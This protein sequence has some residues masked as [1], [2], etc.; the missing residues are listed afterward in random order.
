[1][2]KELSQMTLEELWQLFPIFLTEHKPFWRSWFEEEYNQLLTILPMADVVRISHIGSTAIHNIW[3]K[4][5]IDI[6]VEIRCD[7]E[8]NKM[9]HIIQNSGYILM[10][11]DKMQASFNKGYTPYG[12]AEKVF[13][14][15]LRYSNDNDELYFRDYLNDNPDIAKEYEQ[16]KLAL[17]A[18]HEHNRDAYTE[19]KTDFIKM[20]TEAA[21]AVYG[22]RYYRD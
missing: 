14:L 21:K 17:W 15:H 3:A 16:M 19:S 10:Y 11:S 9:S 13:H 2:K 1:M 22:K 20:H 18:Q 6:L 5:I 4:P 12:F 7:Y 8:L